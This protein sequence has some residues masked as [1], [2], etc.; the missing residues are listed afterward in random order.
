MGPPN[1][2]SSSSSSSSLN[3]VVSSQQVKKSHR[4]K[5]LRRLAAYAYPDLPRIC[6]GLTALVV[7]S[8]TNLSFPWIIGRALDNAGV[9]DVRSLVL[10][11]GGFFLAGSIASWLRVYCLGSALENIVRRLRADLFDSLLFQDLEYYESNQIG[12]VISL[13]ENDAITAASVYTEKLANL[14][15]SLNSSVNGSILLFRTSPRLTAVSLSVVPIVGVGAMALLRYSRGLTAS[16]REVQ[17]KVLSYGLERV[18][19]ITTVRLNHREEYEKEKFDQLLLSSDR[20]AHSKY[21]AEGVFMSFTNIS[22]NLSLVAVLRM[23]G[24]MIAAGQ[25]TLGQLTSFALQTAFVGLGFSGLGSASNEI[26]K[27]LDAADRLFQLLDMKRS[28][29][30]QP[31]LAPTCY[32]STSDDSSSPISPRLLTSSTDNSQSLCAIHVEDV[33]YRYPSRPEV[34]VL[35][36]VNL[37]IVPGRITVF[38]GRSGAGKSTLAALLCGLLTPTEGQI[39]YGMQLLSTRS[40]TPRAARSTSPL[41]LEVEGSSSG[42]GN[43][44]FYPLCGAVEQAGGALFTGTIYDNIAYGKA[45]ATLEEA[46]VVLFTHSEML[47]QLADRLYEVEQGSVREVELPLSR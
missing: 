34:T 14:L 27:A 22:T 18:Q 41:A 19:A 24:Q 38:V 12:E 31:L 4:V 5:T 7:N 46:T 16:L 33:S 25:L 3:S 29:L 42:R 20:L 43:N 13:L 28:D 10:T 45:D 23:G 11:S 8:I 35:S 37:S 39:S 26:V 44:S 47:Q 9:E 6:L 15:R 32:R 17:A 2:S 1:T 21:N 30:H 40:Q 36:H